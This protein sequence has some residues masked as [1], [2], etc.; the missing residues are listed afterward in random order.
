MPIKNI[1]FFLTKSIPKLNIKWYKYMFKLVCL[2]AVLNHIVIF[3][4]SS[5]PLFVCSP[6]VGLADLINLSQ[7]RTLPGL[8]SS[9]SR[10]RAGCKERR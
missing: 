8:W 7:R 10:N 3:A 9:M 5:P 6:A 4:V 1:F 2:Q